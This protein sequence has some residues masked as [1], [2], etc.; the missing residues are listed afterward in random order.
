[1]LLLFVTVVL[2]GVLRR[3]LRGGLRLLL[4]RASVCLID[5]LY[6]ASSFRGVLM[7]VRLCVSLFD[8]Q[9]EVGC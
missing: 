3:N 9:A 8:R 4:G 6:G 7:C 2:I 1:V 5:Q